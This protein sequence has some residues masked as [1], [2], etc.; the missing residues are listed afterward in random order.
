[1]NGF[2]AMGIDQI[3]VKALAAKGI[4][5]PVRVQSWAI[6][7]IMK[8]EDCLILSGTGTGKT[9]TYLLPALMKAE[10]K[11]LFPQVLVITPTRELALQVAQ[12]AKPLSEAM[13]LKT[14]SIF[15][16]RDFFEQQKL[17]QIV[18]GTPGRILD[19]VR[20]GSFSLSGVKLLVLDEV[21]EMLERG[22]LE[23]IDAIS[24]AVGSAR[25]CVVCSATL[26]Q[27]T[28]DLAKDIM[29]SP[30]FFDLSRDEL[31]ME[32]IKL[33]AVK[34][35]A[36]KKIWALDETI[37]RC[38]P[39]LAIVF[40]SSRDSAQATYDELSAKGAECELLTGEMSQSKRLQVMRRFRAAKV[41]IL[42]STDLA[43]R[44][45]DVKGVSHVLHFDLPPDAQQF[46][47]RSGRTGRAGMK[48]EAILFYTPEEGRKLSRLEEKL[49]FT[50]PRANVAGES[51]SVR[52]QSVKSV[53]VKKAPAA[54]VQETDKKAVVKKPKVKPHGRAKAAA[55]LKAKTKGRKK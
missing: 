34:V 50:L 4:R 51:V 26:P 33:S 53:S 3:L 29:K 7:V 10:V 25:Q 27:A 8:G 54:K 52:K 47:H 31:D 1:M 28:R 19:H 18:V 24:E 41:Q 40:C 12:V 32:S 36:D 17:A 13:G 48:G 39:Y 45:I 15:G 14:L 42:V 5:Q 20:E 44:G 35:P 16:G 22:F 2:E 43:A 30:R 37:K 55:K 11:K 23:D 9:F 49:G 46:V 6:P 21:D 38:N